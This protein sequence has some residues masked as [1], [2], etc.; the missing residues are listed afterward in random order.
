MSYK[1]YVYYGARLSKDDCSGLNSY[2]SCARNSLKDNSF[3]YNINSGLYLDWQDIPITGIGDYT[4]YY[5]GLDTGIYTI[6][7]NV[8][9]MEKAISIYLKKMIFA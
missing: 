2:V 7:M 1:T 8:F 3:Y 5:N 6:G 9:E 4:F